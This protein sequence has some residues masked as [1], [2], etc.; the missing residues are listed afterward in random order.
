MTKQVKP[1]PQQ[2]QFPS[3]EDFRDYVSSSLDQLGI[4]AYKVAQLIP[5][6]T[7]S[8]I[9]REIET[10]AKVNPTHRTMKHIF[11]AI[12]GVRAEQDKGAGVS[13]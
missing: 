6:N 12:E 4:T 9:V 5:G 10:G 13:K 1:F 11:D 2:G 7:N 8:N 3:A